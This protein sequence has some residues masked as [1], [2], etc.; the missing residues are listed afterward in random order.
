MEE[1][2]EAAK[3]A[4]H[5]AEI[6]NEHSM[7]S[8]DSALRNRTLL[9]R[10]S[11]SLFA[12]T[13]YLQAGGT[14][15]QSTKGSFWTWVSKYNESCDASAFYFSTISVVLMRDSQ[16]IPILCSTNFYFLYISPEVLS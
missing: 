11:G 1:P 9:A 10:L 15:S 13:N 12:A 2:D 7:L 16:V 6:A 14:V 3:I 4:Y 8:D 5:A